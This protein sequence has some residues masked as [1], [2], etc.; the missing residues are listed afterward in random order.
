MYWK[1]I[2]KLYN[3]LLNMKKTIII[4]HKVRLTKNQIKAIKKNLPKY[5]KHIKEAVK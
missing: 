2:Y 1:S 4:E 3:L 5:I